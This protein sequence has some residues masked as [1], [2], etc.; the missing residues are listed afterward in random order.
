M[1]ALSVH[2]TALHKVLLGFNA[3]IDA[4]RQPV[5]D[6]ILRGAM[7]QGVNEHARTVV[8]ALNITNWLLGAV[9]LVAMLLTGAG[10]GYWFRGAAPILVG[11]H[12]GAEKCDNRADGSRLCWIPIW[13]RLPSQQTGSRSEPR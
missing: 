3:R 12:A 4:V 5:Q 9:A 10:I 13:E 11:V 7:V 8:R 2:L 1:Q 6:D